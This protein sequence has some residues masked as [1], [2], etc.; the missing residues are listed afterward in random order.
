MVEAA[1]DRFG[2]VFDEDEAKRL[3]CR[4]ARQDMVANGLEHRQKTT[5]ARPINGGWTNDDELGVAVLPDFIFSGELAAAVIGDR[6]G[7]VLLACWSWAV[8][9]PPAARLE[10]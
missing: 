6:S 1:D 9:G 2:Q 7:W 3:V 8:A 5:V 10:T 4:W